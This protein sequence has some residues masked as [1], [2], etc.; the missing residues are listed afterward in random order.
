MNQPNYGAILFFLSRYR[1]LYGAILVM[2]MATSVLEAFSVVA[3]F[4]L[5][6]AM[7]GDAQE[8]TGGIAGVSIKLSGYLPMSSA[9]AGA[10]LLLGAAFLVKTV[11]I[12]FR[13]LLVAYAGAKI[14]YD[15][16]Q[17]VM[18]QYSGAEYQ[19]IVDNQQGTL[20]YGSLAAPGSVI[21][22]HTTLALMVISSMKMVAIGTVLVSLLPYPALAFMGMALFYY[23]TMHQISKKITFTL[24]Q[25]RVAANQDQ[26]II[27]NEFLNGFRQIVSFNIQKR[28]IS[29]FEQANRID[30]EVFAKQ[31]AWQSVPRPLLELAAMALL[32]GFVLFLK[33]ANPDT[34]TEQLAGL[35]IFAVALV[36]ILPSLSTFGG[37]RLA[38]MASL[39]NVQLA[40]ETIT[41]SVP[42]RLEGNR[43]LPSFEK[44]IAFEKVS[45][46]HEGRGS[47]MDQVDM[48]FEKGKVTAIV[49]PSGSGKTTLINLIL[50]LFQP[51]GGKIT[52]D[53]IPLRDLTHE[54]WLS[55]IGL[56][57]QD[58]FMYHSTVEENI[59]FSRPEYS[60]EDIIQAAI[61]A[62]AHGFISEMPD[63]YDTLA[64]DRGIKLSGGQQQ[65]ICIAR[66]VLDS[67]EVLLFDEAT[68]AL[69][70]LSERQVQ[71]AMDNASSNRTVIIIAHRLSTIRN[72]DKIIVID[73]GKIVEQGTHQELL[74]NQGLYSRQAAAS[75]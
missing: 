21:I 27:A 17:Q 61:I 67:P 32:L 53:G 5:F 23:M 22:L 46:S 65:R 4:P 15:V 24:A 2:A 7:L 70:S 11:G 55:R 60:R 57:S 19:F 59:R 71:G 41:N 8:N 48:T 73:N 62:N 9:L 72:A 14:H 20:I 63:G 47:L 45:F 43:V 69:D 35:G 31:M 68:S 26:D 51:T 16:K 52:V 66:A 58:P 39:P 75:T 1:F 49:G 34:F 38:L 18:E 29:R 36:Q 3:F 25:K 28:W 12:L 13:D 30:C 74:D 64:G 44:S 40:H 37:S 50:G 56:V 33:A 10:A 6:T 42:A 54:T